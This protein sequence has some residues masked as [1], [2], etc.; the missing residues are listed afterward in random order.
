MLSKL[1]INLG[2]RGNPETNAMRKVVLQ[3]HSTP[4]CLFSDN[5]DPETLVS[6]KMSS[7][8]LYTS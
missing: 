5:V 1:Q 3:T 4:A 7:T 6:V 2:G 8:V